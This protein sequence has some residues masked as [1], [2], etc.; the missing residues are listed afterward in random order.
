MHLL[1]RC[2]V[3][4]GFAVVISSC[5]SVPSSRVEGITS[6]REFVTIL[7]ERHARI[8]RS[9]DDRAL[10]GPLRISLPHA[11]LASGLEQTGISPRQA[12]LVANHAARS[13][14]TAVSSYVSVE[15]PSTPEALHP[16]ITVTGIKA[17]SAVVSGASSVLGIFSP[18]PL[19]IPAGLGALSID[20]E[21]VDSD[22]RQVAAMHWARGANSVTNSARLSSI[23]DAWQLAAKFGKEFARAVLDTDNKRAGLQRARL[24]AADV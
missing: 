6:E 7:D 2:S 16:R 10:K 15:E 14:C 5:A 23:G 3:T 12:Q 24:P 9:V 22:G 17:S 19:R 18:V 1:L 20:A 4:V 11:E 8:A 21:L 13:L